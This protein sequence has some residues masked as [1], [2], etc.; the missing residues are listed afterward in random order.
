M[1]RRTRVI[2]VLLIHKGAVY[3]TIKFKNPQYIGDPKNAI[4][5]FNDLE[6]D[7]IVVLDI[8]ASKDNNNPNIQ[9]IKE[10][11][12]EAFMPFSYGGGI[13]NIKHVKSIL[14]CGVEK[15]IL[16]HSIIQDVA[17]L[18]SIS[19]EIGSSGVVASVDYLNKWGNRQFLFDHVTKK[20]YKI[21]MVEHIQKLQMFGVGEIILNCVDNDGSMNGLD[22]ETL[23]KIQE[24]CEVPLIACGG[25]GTISDL[26]DAESAGASGIA[27]G[28]MFIYFG[29]QKGILINYPKETS[30]RESLK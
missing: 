7:E 17:L 8:D 27:A 25:A 15:V 26:K 16:N 19:N 9:L 18:K 14:K 13:K 28:S 1:I 24:S 10:L 30:L 23:K 29:K 12:S 20:K 4:R 11:A 2:P 21:N 22:I 3:K 5:L 6:V